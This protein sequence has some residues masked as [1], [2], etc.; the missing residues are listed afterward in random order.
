MYVCRRPAFRESA[1][2]PIYSEDSCHHYGCR[3]PF[4]RRPTRHSI[5]PLE[6]DT[7]GLTYRGCDG[8]SRV[9]WKESRRNP[10]RLDSSLSRRQLVVHRPAAGGVSSGRRIRRPKLRSSTSV[11]H[12][13]ESLCRADDWA[14]NRTGSRDS[15]GTNG[16][17]YSIHSGERT[18]AS[19]RRCIKCI[20]QQVNL[21][22]RPINDRSRV[23]ARCLSMN[24]L[25]TVA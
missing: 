15:G 14:S 19:I 13:I 17:E 11:G 2:F 7:L 10:V 3:I 16:R 1:D 9:C 20:D 12:W 23:I 5:P 4:H 22:Y 6:M 21:L 18:T 24:S 25:P 8:I